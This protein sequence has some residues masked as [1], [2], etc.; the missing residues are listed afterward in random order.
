MSGKPEEEQG[1]KWSCRGKNTAELSCLDSSHFCGWRHTIGLSTLYKDQTLV[2]QTLNI[3]CNVL[4]GLEATDGI[5]EQ[6]MRKVARIDKDD[7]KL[8]FLD[9][10]MEN[11]IYYN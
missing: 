3:H 7:I 9:I 8:I 6:P 11:R 10:E 5:I 2:G 1:A 4:I